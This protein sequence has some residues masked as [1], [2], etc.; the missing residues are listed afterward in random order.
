[1][2]SL[3]GDVPIVIVVIGIIGL[4]WFHRRR[5]RQPL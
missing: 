4:A 2:E 5:P 1:M 3:S